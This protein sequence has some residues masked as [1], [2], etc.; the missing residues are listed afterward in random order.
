LQPGE[1]ITEVARQKVTSIQE[2]VAAK[3]TAKNGTLLLRVANGEGTRFVAVPPQFLRKWGGRDSIRFR[4]PAAILAQS[5]YPILPRKPIIR[6]TH[7]N[8]RS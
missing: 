4:N 6:I 3:S 2:A 8:L 1:V 7:P 5:N